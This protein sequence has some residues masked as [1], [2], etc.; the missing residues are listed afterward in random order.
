L[1]RLRQSI[2]LRSFSAIMLFKRSIS[3]LIL[4][5]RASIENAKITINNQATEKP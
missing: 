5:S 3:A 2:Y 1:M 4:R